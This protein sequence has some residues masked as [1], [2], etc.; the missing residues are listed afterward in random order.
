MVMIG[1]VILR[2]KRPMLQLERKSRGQGNIRF[3]DDHTSSPVV[4]VL[5]CAD[6]SD[7]IYTA[8]I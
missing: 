3:G 1:S 5:S 7:G 2:Q 8:K 4:S 6:A